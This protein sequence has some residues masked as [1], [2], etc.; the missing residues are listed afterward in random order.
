MVAGLVDAPS[1]ALACAVP[2]LL[3]LWKREYTVSYGYGGAMACAGALSIARGAASA[4]PLALAHALL[5]V[6]YGLR[7]SLFLLYRESRIP[8]FRQMRERIE[9]LAPKGSRFKRLPFCLSCAGL[10]FCMAAPLKLTEAVDCSSMAAAL[11][12]GLLIFAGYVGLGVAALGDLQK[13]LA[14]ARGEDLVTRGLFA[15]LRHPNYTGEAVLWLASTL[16]ALAAVAGG[17]QLPSLLTAGWAAL[18]LVGCAGIQG[19]L[20]QAT[21]SLERRQRDRYGH[22][23]PYEEW[24]RRAWVGI[25]LPAKPAAEAADQAAGAA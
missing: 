25:T 19:V 14:K 23:A 11:P 7:L 15:R 12:V 22:T 3:G 6:A 10:Y 8:F 1:L 21:S 18:S 20:A 4:S 2:S 9:T 13:T 17:G 5:Y 24:Q 16:A